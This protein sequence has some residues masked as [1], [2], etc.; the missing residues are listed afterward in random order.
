[1]PLKIAETL[2]PLGA[3]PYYARWRAPETAR[4]EFVERV[5]QLFWM[6]KLF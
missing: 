5:I 2:I 6:R 3:L 1:M 4:F